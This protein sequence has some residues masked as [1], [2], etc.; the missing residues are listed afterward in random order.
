MSRGIE[1]PTQLLP[2]AEIG[3][4]Q[5]EIPVAKFTAT[6]FDVSLT[7]DEVLIVREALSVLSH[8]SEQSPLFCGEYSDSPSIFQITDLLEQFK[9][10]VG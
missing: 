3:T 2:L 8:N 6:S 7:L 1:S 5:Q 4:A 10:I 9:K